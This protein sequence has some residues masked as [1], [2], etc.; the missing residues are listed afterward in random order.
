MGLYFSILSCYK[1]VLGPSSASENIRPHVQSSQLVKDI[2]T[3]YTK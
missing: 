1:E 3:T 2:S